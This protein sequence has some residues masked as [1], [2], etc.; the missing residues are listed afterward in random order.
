MT[1]EDVLAG[2][3]RSMVWFGLPAEFAVGGV[4]LKPWTA[5]ARAEFWAWRKDHPGVEGLNE[6]LAALSLCDETGALLFGDPAELAHA[7]GGALELIGSRVIE[8]NGIG[9]SAPGKGS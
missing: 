5:A 3:K 9:A 2:L 6:K 8:L 1:R 7:D 4:W